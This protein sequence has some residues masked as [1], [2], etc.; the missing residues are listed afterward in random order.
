MNTTPKIPMRPEEL[1]QQRA[2]V[3]SLPPRPA[4][5][6][7]MR[8]PPESIVPPVKMPRSAR[9]IAQV[10]WAWSP[11]N[12]RLDAYYLSTNSKRIHWLLWLRLYDDNW[13]KWDEPQI[14]AYAPK[15]HV[16]SKV[17]AVY[18]LLDS[19]KAEARDSDLDRFHWVNES[20]FLSA[21]E[22]NAIGRVVWPT[23]A[24]LAT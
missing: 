1:P 2:T 13:G 11:T 16:P 6:E 4:G 14:Y 20:E 22:L 17:A 23:H 9:Y 21:E 24:N 18:L 3:A 19:W 7:G 15:Q 12:T 8:E 10:E 5:F